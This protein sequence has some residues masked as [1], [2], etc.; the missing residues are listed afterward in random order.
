[1]HPKT[2]GVSGNI[3]R[4]VAVTLAMSVGVGG[5]VFAMIVPWMGRKVIMTMA[6]GL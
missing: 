1:M 2:R 6:E 5:F 4:A 3:T